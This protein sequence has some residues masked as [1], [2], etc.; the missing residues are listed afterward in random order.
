MPRASLGDEVVAKQH[1]TLGLLNRFFYRQSL[2]LD[3]LGRIKG[4]LIDLVT[5]FVLGPVSH[6]KL[7]WEN[8]L[9]LTTREHIFVLIL[10]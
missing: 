4:R 9:F 6:V 10:V 8:Y 7:L 5:L 2:S 3:L 1:I